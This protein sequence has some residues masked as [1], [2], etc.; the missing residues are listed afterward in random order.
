[1]CKSGEPHDLTIFRGS[2]CGTLG[3]ETVDGDDCFF[4]AF[5]LYREN[6][7]A[8]FYIQ[9]YVHIQSVCSMFSWLESGWHRIFKNLKKIRGDKMSTLEK[10][11]IKFSCLFLVDFMAIQRN[12]GRS[13][14]PVFHR[15]FHLEGRSDLRKGTLWDLSRPGW[16]LRSNGYE[17]S[18]ETIQK[19]LDL[20]G[21]SSCERHLQGF[22]NILG[23]TAVPFQPWCL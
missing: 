10:Y 1:M 14:R 7:T 9:R 15:L 12:H 6:P 11:Q 5:F 17:T 21:S 3:H 13:F 22:G 23:E 18:L 16:F 8:L 19:A 4:S 2:S 20:L